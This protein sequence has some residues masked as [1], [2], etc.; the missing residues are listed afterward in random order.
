MREVG[1]CWLDKLKKNTRKSA[2]LFCEEYLR[3]FFSASGSC[4]LLLFCST[5][6][7]Q[8]S[9]PLLTN[10]DS[11]EVW[12]DK[13]VD[14]KNSSLVNG[15]EY[16]VPFKGL[17]THPFYQSPE[18]DR[19]FIHYD[20]DLYNN[21]DLL[22][23]SYSDA[24]VLK[25]VTSNG[26]LFIKLDTRLVQSFDLHHHHFKKYDEGIRADI[27]AY[28]DVLFEENHYAVVAKRRKLERINGTTS[29]YI[30]DDVY[31]ILNQGKWIR[32]TGKGSFSTHLN[33]EQKKELAAFI[34]KNHINVR[35]R[36]EA[37]LKTL[38]AFCYSLQEKKQ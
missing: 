23:D 17:T 5:A 13:I 33:K 15:F 28:F 29:D 12:F 7:A 34:K 8:S 2:E 30:E 38:G 24:V 35:K 25:S 26:A 10:A 19:T 20:H 3:K 27:G 32:I 1:R 18:S 6:T 16:R 11:A 22:Y 36:D 21:V 4:L 14:P 31:Y 9:Y 37:D